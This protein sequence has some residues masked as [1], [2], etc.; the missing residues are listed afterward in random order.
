MEEILGNLS[1]TEDEKTHVTTKKRKTVTQSEN[2]DK[3]NSAI[4]APGIESVPATISGALSEQQEKE[5]IPIV[6][7]RPLAVELSSISTEMTTRYIGDMSPYPLLAQMI[8][9]EDA[10]VASQIGVKIRRFGQSLVLYE[11][12]DKSGKNGNQKLLESLGM[13]KPGETIK[14]LN[15]WIYKVAGIDKTTS[16]SLMKIFFAYIHPGLPVVNKK[17]F[18]KQ[19]RGEIGEYPSAP[20]LNAIY[21][22]AVRYIETCK[23][24]GDEVPLEHQVEIKDGWSEKLFE[25]IIHYV[26]DRYNPC[27]S[28]VQAIVITQNH[29]ASLDE[30][31]ASGWLLSSAATRMAQDLGL[32][33]ASESWDI[34]TSEKET[35]RRVW[36]SVYIID[37]WTAAATGRPQTIFDEDCDEIYP[38]ESADWEEV[39]DVP[40]KDNEDS[41][42]P[43]YPSLDKNVA[44]KAKSGQIPIYQP[45][46]QLVKLSEILGRL[47]QG[48]YTPLAKKHSEKHGSDAIVTYLDNSLSEWRAA[49]P[50]ALQISHINVRRL[51]SHGRTPL[52]SMSGLMYL[53]YCTLLIL[54]HRPFIENNGGMTRSSQ[55]SLSICT[56]AATRC[57]DIAEKMHY[58]DFLLVSWNFAMYPV[59]TA[60]LIHIYNATNPDT[61]VSDVAKSN[62][63][64]ACSVIKRMSKISIAAARLYDVLTQLTKIRDISMDE[65]LQNR[66]D[67]EEEDTFKQE[68]KLLCASYKHKPLTSLICLKNKVPNTSF[69]SQQQTFQQDLYPSMQQ[70]IQQ[71]LQSNIPLESEP[72]TLRQFG[73]NP[74]DSFLFGLTD[75]NF[76]ASASNIQQPAVSSSFN[77][78]DSHNNT[79]SFHLSS[80]N[81]VDQ[82][83]FRNRPDNP[84][85]SVPSSIELDDWTAYLLPQQ[86]PF[87]TSTTN[88]TSNSIA[89][90]S[91][92]QQSV[93]STSKTSWPSSTQ[94]WM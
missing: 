30:K 6:D 11:K 15:E 53:S 64:R 90:T 47:L 10:R 3:L 9:F 86:I 50:P 63:W 80:A 26:K 29:R 35:R 73:L 2:K 52:L 69:S 39:M 85:W 79:S 14:S 82:T 5:K 37:K 16:D 75:I 32:H 34:P 91:Q 33:R 65:K 18:L 55:S 58:R 72:Y 83:V 74:A 27:I 60:S 13:L 49:L 46:V 92:Q 24:F 7:S 88:S 87:P 56:S 21:G 89:S 31:I 41:E 66:S 4:V 12:D 51:D 59:F 22:S 36:W 81:M 45:F 70:Q 77:T 42:A 43:R 67:D 78:L 76:A 20:L 62:L 93:P 8:N 40:S 57:V 94:G 1:N 28:T 71:P 17:L 44:R 68:Q 84:F 38:N 25:N 23:L 48:L 61:I 54:L 19:Y